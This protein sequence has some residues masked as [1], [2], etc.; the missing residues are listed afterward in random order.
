M[1]FGSDRIK[2]LLQS[3]KDRVARLAKASKD[4]TSTPDSGEKEI[5]QMKDIYRIHDSEDIEEQS[6][7]ESEE[8]IHIGDGE[9]EL[10]KMLT[11]LDNE[12]EQRNMSEQKDQ[13]RLVEIKK[14]RESGSLAENNALES[15]EEEIKKRTTERERERERALHVME[16]FNSEL[17]HALESEEEEI[18]LYNVE[19]SGD[20]D[21]GHSRTHRKPKPSYCDAIYHQRTNIYTI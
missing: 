14:A 8:E 13:I 3:A 21:K 6:D 18:N 17:K 16:K 9:K 20:G 4:N 10:N 1:P 2:K 15:E 7:I 19:D 12:D 5:K 11:E